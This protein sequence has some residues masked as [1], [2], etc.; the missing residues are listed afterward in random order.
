[1]LLLINVTELIKD[2]TVIK[3]DLAVELISPPSPFF[4][5][6]C[7]CWLKLRL[8]VFLLSML[9]VLL[10]VDSE[11]EDVSEIKGPAD[12]LPSQKGKKFYIHCMT[13]NS[14][15]WRSKK[16]REF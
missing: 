6:F 16:K 5:G 13:L 2:S 10:L 8:D 14:R 4:L 3:A 15:K 7:I 11:D 1:M 9:Y 12:W